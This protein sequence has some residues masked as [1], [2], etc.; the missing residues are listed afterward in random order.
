MPCRIFVT[1]ETRSSYVEMCG[2]IECGAISAMFE[3]DG[4]SIVWRDFASQS[5]DPTDPD[6]GWYTAFTNVPPMRFE[7][8]VS[9]DIAS[10]D[11]GRG[12][13]AIGVFC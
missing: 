2:D 5:P 8:R 9:R 12:R 3:R 10:D 13:C 1:G 11:P 4:G 7:A 6:R